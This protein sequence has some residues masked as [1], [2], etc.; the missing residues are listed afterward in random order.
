MK[1][2]GFTLI[3]LLV[4]VAIIGILA[5]VVLASLGSARDR[6]KQVKFIATLNQLEKEL[7]VSNPGVWWGEVPASS[8]IINPASGVDFS[9]FEPVYDGYSFAY[10]NDGDTRINASCYASE[11][12]TIQAVNVFIFGGTLAEFLELNDAIDT[13][14]ANATEAD[15][16]LCG[17]FMWYSSSGGV[18]VYRIA[19]NSYE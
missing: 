5:T 11:G 12:S 18:M 10:D 6:A 3:E 9:K 17:K 13:S 19:N 7:Q 2:R 4:V 15:K 8:G 16:R 1:S 14:E